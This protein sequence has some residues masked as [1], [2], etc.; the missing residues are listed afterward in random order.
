MLFSPQWVWLCATVVCRE[1]DKPVGCGGRGV[2]GT[3]GWCQWLGMADAMAI[4]SRTLGAAGAP[5]GAPDCELSPVSS[6]RDTAPLGL[7]HLPLDCRWDRRQ[8]IAKSSELCTVSLVIRVLVL[9]TCLG[10]ISWKAE[11]RGHLDRASCTMYAR[12]GRMEPRVGEDWWDRVKG[13]FWHVFPSKPV[14]GMIRVAG[15]YDI[16]S[17][18]FEREAKCRYIQ[19]L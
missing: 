3:S 19:G 1:E 9:M 12:S 18:L 11:L 17:P 7:K 13:S 4:C 6:S 14:L 2:A 10:K 8:V 16:P 5:C 15:P